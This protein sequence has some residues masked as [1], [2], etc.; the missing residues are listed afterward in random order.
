MPK[1]IISTENAPAA[2]GAYSQGVVVTGNRTLFV[3]GQ[4]PFDPKTMEMVGKGDVRAQAEQVMRNLG[5]V[6]EAAGMGFG[7]VVRATIFLADMG[8]FAAV[9]EVYAT[10]FESDPPARAA[11]AVKEL[12]KGVDVEISCIAVTD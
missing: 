11:V 8:D 7:D 12:P 4:I 3:S 1:Q 6:L 2:I 10:R 9:N 5:G